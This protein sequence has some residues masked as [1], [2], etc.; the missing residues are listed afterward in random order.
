MRSFRHKYTRRTKWKSY[1]YKIS[2]LK[3][4]NWLG[5][6]TTKWKQQR[7]VYELEN[8]L[9][10]IIQG[11]IDYKWM[12]RVSD[13]SGTTERSL[14]FGIPEGEEKENRAGKNIWRNNNWKI[15]PKLVKDKLKDSKIQW[16]TSNIISKKST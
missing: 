8:K 2:Y 14:T 6:L 1:I 3:L 13:I 12:N 7:K 16:T 5:G 4:K 15:S 11:E 10:E 9:T